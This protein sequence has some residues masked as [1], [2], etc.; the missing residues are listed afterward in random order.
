METVIIGGI[1]VISQSILSKA[2][3]DLYSTIRRTSHKQ[4][5]NVLREINVQSDVEVIEELLKEIT[6][7]PEMAERP[8]I[9]VCVKQIHSLIKNIDNEIEQMNLKIV[10]QHYSKYYYLPYIP[11]SSIWI[12]PDYDENIRNVKHYKQL[13]SERLSTLILL[14]K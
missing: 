2:I 8:I 11:Y 1:G 4:L 13:L 7:S 12:K 14:T 9:K 5:S 10:D 3:G 6:N